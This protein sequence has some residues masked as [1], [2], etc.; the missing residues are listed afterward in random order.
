[1]FELC[2]VLMWENR[3]RLM[4]GEVGFSGSMMVLLDAGMGRAAMT[5]K[6]M[7]KMAAW[8]FLTQEKLRKHAAGVDI[9]MKPDR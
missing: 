1:M 9:G 5:V 3:K 2:Q 7:M 4:A 6:Q 8:T